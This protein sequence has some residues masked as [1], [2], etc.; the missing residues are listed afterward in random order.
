MT[1]PGRVTR[2]SLTNAT[3]DASRDM[4]IIGVIIILISITVSLVSII[5]VMCVHVMRIAH[6]IRIRRI[7]VMGSVSVRICLI[8]RKISVGITIIII[9]RI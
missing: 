8:N 4:R 6:N 1:M 2:S 5:I 3:S 7:I 9:S